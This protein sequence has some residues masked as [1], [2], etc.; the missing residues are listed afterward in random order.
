MTREILAL[1]LGVGAI[2]LSAGRAHGETTCL[3]RAE[4]VARL[5]DQ[6]GE[7]RQA[8]GLAGPTQVLELFAS[9]TSGTWTITV[10]TPSGQTCLLAAG[11]HYEAAVE[12]LPPP[13]DPA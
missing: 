6:Y 5:A 13:G 4:M 1:S 11:D 7:S 12:P 9:P 8:I 3:A 2:L 10:T